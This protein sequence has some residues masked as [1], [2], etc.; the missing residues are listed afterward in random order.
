MALTFAHYAAPSLAH[1]LAAAAVVGAHRR[2][3]APGSTRPPALT[4]AIVAVVL[5]V[6]RGRSSSRRSPAAP[7]RPRTCSDT[8]GGA[9]GVLRAA[10]FL[11]FAFAGYARIATLGEEV[12]DPARTIPRAIPIALGITL[13][14]YAVVARRGAAR[15]RRPRCWPRPTR[16]SRRSSARAR[17]TR[18]PR[19]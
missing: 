5:V 7:S 10:G 11:F 12:R 17:C 4:R 6:A 8:H 16:R 9:Y 19:S 15:R 18:S 13:A 1:P 14:V 2:E 3:P